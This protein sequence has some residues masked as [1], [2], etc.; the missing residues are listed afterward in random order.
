VT[1]SELPIRFARLDAR[2]QQYA[3]YHLDVHHAEADAAMVRH[4][5]TM[6]E[7]AIRETSD[8]DLPMLAWQVV[9]TREL[10]RRYGRSIRAP[11]LGSVH[12]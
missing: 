12:V 11:R 3:P 7:Q 5:P 1:H 6:T 10:L 4:L 8:D 2:E 9:L